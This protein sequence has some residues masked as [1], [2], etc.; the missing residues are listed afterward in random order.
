MSKTITLRITLL[1][2]AFAALGGEAFAHA[3]LKSARPGVGS[4][5]ATSPR[6]LE[7]DFSEGVVPSFSGIVLHDQDGR[8]VRLGPLAKGSSATTLVAP[9][10]GSL[11]DG[12]YT[13]TWHA[14][15]VDTHRTQGSFRFTVGH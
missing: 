1:L 15:S 10:V 7:L 11:S 3:M 4:T 2:I 6:T 9:I 12:T 14:V 5:F 8:V 13:V